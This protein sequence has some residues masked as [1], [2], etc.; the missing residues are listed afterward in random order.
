MHGLHEYGTRHG[1]PQRPIMSPGNRQSAAALQRSAPIPVPGACPQPRERDS[2]H[3]E[4]AR[5]ATSAMPQWLAAAPESPD[6][7]HPPSTTL[8]IPRTQS[9]VAAPV[10]ADAA[11]TPPPS[12]P[13]Q[14]TAAAEMVLEHGGGGG[15]DGPAVATGVSEYESALADLEAIHAQ[16]SSSSGSGGGGIFYLYR[17]DLTSADFAHVIPVAE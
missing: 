17:L 12:T 15:G 14:P 8:Q 10:V 4:L 11:P 5:R 13:P 1:A 3:D 6:D 7:S 16:A 9:L 2:R